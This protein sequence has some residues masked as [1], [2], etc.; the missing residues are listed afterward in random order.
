MAYRDQLIRKYAQL[1]N[2]QLIRLATYEAGGLTPEAREVLR[3]ELRG[4]QLGGGLSDVI[5]IQQREIAPQEHDELVERFRKLPCP[6][7]NSVGRP[8]NAVTVATARSFLIMTTHQKRVVLGCPE[9]ILA[10]ARKAQRLTLAFAWWGIPWGPIRGLQAMVL[11]AEARSAAARQEA[12]AELYNY[13]AANRGEVLLLLQ[14]A[15]SDLTA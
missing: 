7:C 9:C 1:S 10:A 13:V 2:D 6:I 12:T 4:R 5:D 8:L 15:V 3:E 11:N 14:G